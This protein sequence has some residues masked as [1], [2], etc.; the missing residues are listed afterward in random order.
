MSSIE[1]WIVIV[2]LLVATVIA[3]SGFWLFGNRFALPPRV[4]EALRYAP[5]CALAAIIAP[6][7]FLSD[8]R[9]DL[10]FDNPRLMAGILATAFFLVRKNMLHTIFFGMAVYTY[11]RLGLAA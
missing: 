7:L 5:A 8:G 6:D 3:R 10:S 2:L 4:N 9:L 11:I 1:I